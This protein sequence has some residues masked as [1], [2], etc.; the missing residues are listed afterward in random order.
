M[1]NIDRAQKDRSDGPAR[2]ALGLRARNKEDKRQ[3]L[4]RA[5][6]A[7]FSRHGFEATTA[8]EIAA[9]AGVASG[10]FFVY[11][12]EKRDLLMALFDRDVQAL[13]HDAF[14]SVPAEA[15]V[16]DQ[17]M[18]VFARTYEY[19]DRDQRLA[20]VFLKEL[21]FVEPGERSDVHDHTLGLI[22]RIATLVAAA[23]E[24]REVDARVD[25]LQV[26]THVFAL[27]YFSLVTWLN[28][29]LPSRELVQAH[30]EGQ[31][32]LVLTGIGR[33]GGR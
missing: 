4:E 13:A 12:R 1:V 20:R 26:A 32:E 28:G 8:R 3:R 5:G 18:H 24:R 17:L 27:Y 6:R 11:F 14:A 9:K 16:V 31:L 21:L 19:Y 29:A 30:M 7:L 33:R 23:K 22:G 10:T 2:R 15:P 25:A